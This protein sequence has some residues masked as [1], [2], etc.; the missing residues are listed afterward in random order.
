MDAP[1]TLARQFAPPREG[2]NALVAAG[3][4]G[5]GW[6]ALY[7]PVYWEFA[8]GPWRRDENAHAPIMLAL[9]AGAAVARFLDGGFALNRSAAK[10]AAGALALTIGLGAYLMG[11]ATDATLIVSASQ[12]LVALGLAIFFFGVDGARRLW[13]P[14]LMFSYL[15]IWPGWALDALTLPLKMFVSQATAEGL[16]AIGMPVAHAG[17]VLTAGP[18]TLL[19]ADACS[20]LNSLIALTSVGA[21]YLYVARRSDWRI[22]MIV[23]TALIPIAIAANIGRVC[24]LVAI[25]YYLGYDAGQSFLH[26]GAGFVMFALALGLVFAVDAVA[27]AVFAMATGR[28]ARS[29]GRGKRI[30]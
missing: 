1:T 27:A 29:A 10:A 20:G 7:G 23:L 9:I 21:V 19:V 2:R 17:A 11:R 8:L 5:A 13:F 14:L 24:L 30:A 18:Y 25:T 16:Y 28:D 26:E 22:N 12:G 4:I 3:V 6:L 15:I